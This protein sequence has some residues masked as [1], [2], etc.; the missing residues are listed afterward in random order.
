MKAKAIYYGPGL[1]DSSASEETRIQ[2]NL[3]ETISLVQQVEALVNDLKGA[4][5]VL[6]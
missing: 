2:K 1:S 3:K 5:Y 6:E 4:K